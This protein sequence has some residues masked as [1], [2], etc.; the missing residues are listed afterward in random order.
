VH[1]SLAEGDD[2]A[3]ASEVLR[4]H[5]PLVRQIR[6]RFAPL[7]A[8]RLRLRRQRSGD[9]LDLD[10]CVDA[11]TDRRVGSAP[12]DRLYELSR[13]TR[14]SVAI[15]LLVDVSG[16]TRTKLADG[17]TIF[18][19]E[20]MTM[21]LASEA[22]ATLGDPYA[23]L[24]FSG[25]GRHHV[26][27][28][29]VKAFDEHDDPAVRRRISALVASENTRLGAAVRHATSVLAAQSAQRRVL[30]VLSD[31]RPNDVDRYQGSF[32]I[33]DSRHALLAARTSGVHP[34]CLTVDQEEE[35]YLPR[36]FGEHGYLVLNEPA[37][38]P[39]A[40]LRVVD[41]LLRA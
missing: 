3:W 34:F 6:D 26:Q 22:L 7:R 31:G 11:H 19:V 17:R 30:L 23:M 18:D 36:L 27:M 8:R 25:C 39:N 21:L 41:R 33:E 40:L 10:A 2:D 38:L 32:A 14:H 35:E 12:S 24:A 37:Q 16:S 5:A 13:P 15:L 9:E 1:C 28:R 29:T 4:Q 20:R